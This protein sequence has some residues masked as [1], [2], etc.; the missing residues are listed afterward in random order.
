MNTTLNNFEDFDQNKFAQPK[1]T[2]VLTPSGLAQKKPQSPKKRL[3]TS[4]PNIY[5][6]P[7]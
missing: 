5:K 6:I 1:K 7:A 2:S 4:K 3:L